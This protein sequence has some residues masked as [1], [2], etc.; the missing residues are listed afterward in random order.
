MSSPDLSRLDDEQ[1]IEHAGELFEYIER[2][3]AE[4]QAHS[5][6]FKE[7]A[8]GLD[9]DSPIEEERLT[10]VSKRQQETT[11]KHRWT[12]IDFENR[13]LSLLK[14]WDND[15]AVLSI[16]LIYKVRSTRQAMED[17]NKRVYKAMGQQKGL[18]MLAAP[19][20]TSYTFEMSHFLGMARS[21]GESA[22]L[23]V[24]AV[25]NGWNLDE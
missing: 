25:H 6:A 20:L 19:T 5:S 11:D 16:A 7:A 3:I 4:A 10:E 13:T 23:R 24:M 12:C 14:R 22:M 8:Q 2:G 18:M 9:L 15:K 1:M 21:M 17:A